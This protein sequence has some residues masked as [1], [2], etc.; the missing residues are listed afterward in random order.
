MDNDTDIFLESEIQNRK[1]NRLS[2]PGG[3]SSARISFK[4]KRV[5]L[6]PEKTKPLFDRRG[7]TSSNTNSVFSGIK[8]Q[9]RISLQDEIPFSKGPNSEMK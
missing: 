7:S 6:N 4:E 2:K 8:E 3:S 5:S 9:R 1:K